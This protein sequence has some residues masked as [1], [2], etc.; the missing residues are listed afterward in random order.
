M[1]RAVVCFDMTRLIL[2]RHAQSESNQAKF[3]AAQTNVN[4]TELGR[5]QAQETARFLKDHPIDVAYSS[6][7]VRVIQTAKP[8]VKDRG[9]SLIPTVGLREINGGVWEGLPY[10]EIDAKYPNERALWYKDIVNCVCPGG[11]S[12]RD[13]FI[14]ASRTIDD[15]LSESRG[16]NILIA[17][18]ATVIRVLLTRFHGVPLEGIKDIPWPENAS[19][20]IVDYDDEGQFHIVL[21]GYN[22]HLK[23]AGLTPA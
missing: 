22:E 20:T 3:Y 9:L 2:V 23:K 5:A 15:I 8:I 12:V 16:K 14:R 13:V 17:S 19:V 4:L 6:D 7:Y 11:D 18:H 10:S 21:Q 1:M